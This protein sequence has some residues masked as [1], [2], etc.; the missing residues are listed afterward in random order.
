MTLSEVEEAID[1]L[2]RSGDIFEP[3][4]GIIEHIS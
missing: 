3:K 4:P 1:K 2:K